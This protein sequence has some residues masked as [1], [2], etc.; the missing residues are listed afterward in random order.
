M[1]KTTY[2]P[3][4]CPVC[5]ANL[6]RVAETVHETYVFNPDKGIYTEKDGEATIEC[7]ECGA[8]LYDVFPQGVC[9]YVHPSKTEQDTNEE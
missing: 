5:G 4:R 6:F 1:Q 9:N 3:P 2:E 8:D 7:I